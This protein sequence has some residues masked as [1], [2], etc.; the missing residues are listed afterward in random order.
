[1]LLPLIQRKQ[2][3]TK[4]TR[5]QAVQRVIADAATDIEMAQ[6]LSHTPI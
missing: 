2:L 3:G 5:L 1:M 6:L 4:L